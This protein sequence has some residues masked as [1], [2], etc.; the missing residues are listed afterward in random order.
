MVRPSGFFKGGTKEECKA[1][2]MTNGECQIFS[3]VANGH[4]QPFCLLMRSASGR[5]LRSKT[6]SGERR[7]CKCEAWS[8][9][10]WFLCSTFVEFSSL[11]VRNKCFSAEHVSLSCVDIASR[12][13]SVRY[14]GIIFFCRKV[15]ETKNQVSKWTFWTLFDPFLSNWFRKKHLGLVTTYQC[16]SI[17]PSLNVK[18]TVPS[19]ATSLNLSPQKLLR[20]SSDNRSTSKAPWK[21][22]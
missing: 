19:F 17:E 3:Y 9:L 15:P 11:P 8:I 4:P 14:L 16:F 20:F 1:K 6:T 7:N 13:L 5:S 2:C 22:S 21:A 10:L 18:C 12:R